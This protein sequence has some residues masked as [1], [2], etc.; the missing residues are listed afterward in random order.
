MAEFCPACWNRINGARYEQK[1]IVLTRSA[2]LCEGCGEICRLVARLR[3]PW[4]PLWYR[5]RRPF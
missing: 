1:D 3:R 5:L 2:D 4:S